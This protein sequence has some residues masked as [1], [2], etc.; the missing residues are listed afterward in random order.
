MTTA[1]CLTC[2]HA[3]WRKTVTGRLH[4]SGDGKCR[5]EVTVPIPASTPTW[6]YGRQAT[7]TSTITIKGGYIRRHGASR[8]ICRTYKAKE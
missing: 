1:A 8:A 5:Y 2:A 3:E 4:P 7:D 6:G